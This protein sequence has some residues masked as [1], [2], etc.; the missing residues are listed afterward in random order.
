MKPR[1]RSARSRNKN[2]NKN[3]KKKEN[4]SLALLLL[5]FG[6]PRFPRRR[7]S[8]QNQIT[9]NR[10]HQQVPA[11][12]ET[13]PGGFGFDEGYWKYEKEWEPRLLSRTDTVRRAAPA[14]RRRPLLWALLAQ[15]IESLARVVMPEPVQCQVRLGNAPS[16]GRRMWNVTTRCG[17]VV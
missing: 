7:H 8:Q 3:E 10:T 9:K 12:D 13:L 6:L 2:K 14:P 5:S 15:E 4:S 16:R 11:D 17:G 1:Q